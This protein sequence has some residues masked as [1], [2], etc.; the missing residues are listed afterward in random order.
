MAKALACGIRAKWDSHDGDDMENYLN[1]GQHPPNL[2][3]RGGYLIGYLVAQNVAKTRS[4]SQIG[5]LDGDE[6]ERRM[7]SGVDALCKNGV[8]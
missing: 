5:K 8:I 1:A 2:P 3:A 6:L 7:R 4:L